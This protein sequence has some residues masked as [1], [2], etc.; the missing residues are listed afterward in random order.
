MLL[1]Q[2]NPQYLPLEYG[3]SRLALLLLAFSGAPHEDFGHALKQ[4]TKLDRRVRLAPSRAA[5]IRVFVLR[6]VEMF[7]L[8]GSATIL[9]VLAAATRSAAVCILLSI[10]LFLAYAFLCIFFPSLRGFG[11]F[12]MMA[13]T[14]SG[15]I[16]LAVAAAALTHRLM[17]IRKPTCEEAEEAA[18]Q[19]NESK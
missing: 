8:L 18:R 14:Y 12:A 15:G 6:Q 4:K 3:N 13:C 19:P 11:V 17:A 5:N 2:I 7:W 1:Q 9:G 10:L 16:I